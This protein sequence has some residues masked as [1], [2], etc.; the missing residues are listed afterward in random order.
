MQGADDHYVYPDVTVVCGPPELTRHDVLANP[1]ALVEVLS[2]TTEQYDR[3][4]KWEGYQ[5]IAALQDYVLVSQAEP[6]IELFRRGTDGTWI[7]QAAG[8]G[9]ALTLS[10]GAVLDVDAIFAGTAELPGD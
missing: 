9:Q 6:R 10:S 2:S 3:G 4:L 7:Y 5:R 1:T 8:A